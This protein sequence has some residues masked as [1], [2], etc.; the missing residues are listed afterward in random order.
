MANQAT[1]P[2]GN[3]AILGVNRIAET[4][5]AKLKEA[6]P[7]DREI[8][9]F[10]SIES[11]G[12]EPSLAD[13]D[14]I[15]GNIDDLPSIVKSKEINKV[16][17]AIDPND[18]HTL[19]E[20][21]QACEAIHLSYEALP[22]SYDINYDE[23]TS[24]EAEI[25][26]EGD[27]QKDLWF[28]RIVDLVASLAM[29]LLFLPSYA[30]VALAIKLESKGD[31]LYSQERVGKNGKIFKIYKFRSMYID[32]EAQGPQLATKRDPRITNI[33][34]ILRKTRIDELPQLVN[35]IRGD[36]SLIGPRPERPF[37]VE[38]YS[39][40]IPDYKKRLAVKPGLTGWAQVTVGYDESL[41][42]VK[43]KVR[44]D[45]YYIQ[46]RSSVKLYFQIVMKTI[47]VVVTASGQ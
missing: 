39:K 46:N 21:I 16:V 26:V 27:G 47:W 31:V 7:F 10:I 28:Q 11:N 40:E 24:N 15:L 9:G 20:V 42:D 35:V 36:M 4:L 5:H 13:A 14:H 23:T 18:K 22:P 38:K 41:D 32:A 43:E 34:R 2:N 25:T 44:K 8:V 1:S 12:A 19:H 17:L 30:F 29:F 33:G 45:L 3:L 37:H 6:N